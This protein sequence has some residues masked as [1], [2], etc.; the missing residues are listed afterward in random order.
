MIVANDLHRGLLYTIDGNH[1]SVAQW[2]TRKGF[3]DV[4]VYAL[5]HVR[6]TE[7]AYV[8]AAA[9]ELFS[10]NRSG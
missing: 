5:V 8:P 1:R 7:W 4:P 3:Q 9:R 10:S 2:L 6:L